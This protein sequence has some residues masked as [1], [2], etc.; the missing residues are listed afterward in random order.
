MV[1]GETEWSVPGSLKTP[2]YTSFMKKLVFSLFS[3]IALYVTYHTASRASQSI[4][5]KPRRARNTAISL[6]AP[7][8]FR[9]AN[10]VP[11]TNLEALGIDISHAH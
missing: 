4:N 8:E 3:L 11:A 2:L 5:P 7:A 6:E 10:I 9:I 1:Q